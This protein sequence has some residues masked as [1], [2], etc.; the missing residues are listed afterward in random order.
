MSIAFTT[1]FNEAGN[2][3]DSTTPRLVRYVVR[4]GGLYR[5]LYADGVIDSTTHQPV[6]EDVVIPY[7]LNDDASPPFSYTYIDGDAIRQPE[8]GE[9]PVHQVPPDPGDLARI[10]LVGIH[11]LVDLDRNKSPNAMDITTQ[12]QLRNQ[13]IIE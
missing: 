8:P 12:A 11:V 7:L 2:E 13:R 1:T 10:Q 4:N 9:D 6:R 5:D 3:L